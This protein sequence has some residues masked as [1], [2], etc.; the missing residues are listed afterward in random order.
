[1]S[2]Y[3]ITGNKGK[4]DE[5]K[6]VIPEVEQLYLDLPELQGLDSHEIIHEKLLAAQ[7]HSNDSFIVEDTSFT[8]EGMNG[9]PGPLSKWFL[10]SIGNEGIVRLS[11]IFGT[12]AFAKSTIGYSND[13]KE[14]AFFEGV[15]EGEIVELKGEASRGF[16]W[17]PIFKPKGSDKS[18]G[19]MEPEEKNMVSMRRIATE[20]L[21]SYLT[22]L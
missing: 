15:I 9:L 1:V 20:R 2:L 21:K 8:L 16:G 13:R 17:D 12:K 18:F 5:A 11:K 7:K 6:A 4:F 22:K 14:I 19:E 10:K 3:F